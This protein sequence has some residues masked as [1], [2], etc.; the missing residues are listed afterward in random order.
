MWIGVTTAIVVDLAPSKIRTAAV[1]LYLFNIT[2]IGGNFNVLVAPLR[3]GFQLHFDKLTS[4]RWSLFLTF[5]GLYALN[6]FLFLLTFF[7]MWWDLRRKRLLEAY[8]SRAVN[9]DADEGYAEG[10]GEMEREVG[11]GEGEYAEEKDEE[12]GKENKSLLV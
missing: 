2:V 11:D 5:P 7:V 4:Y 6:S 12:E 1:A 3:Q 8:S 9:P 10:E